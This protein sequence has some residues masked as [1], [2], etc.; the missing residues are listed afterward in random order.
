MPCAEQKNYDLIKRDP[1]SFEERV[2]D[3]ISDIERRCILLTLVP[4]AAWLV[5]HLKLDVESGVFIKRYI[6]WVQ[7]EG[8]L[9]P[10]GDSIGATLFQML[11][12]N[13]MILAESKATI[14]YNPAIFNGMCM[15]VVS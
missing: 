9:L 1:C 2:I 7:L 15:P 12:G 10:E 5:N 11:N 3:C 14:Y 4:R 13:S 8:G 6:E